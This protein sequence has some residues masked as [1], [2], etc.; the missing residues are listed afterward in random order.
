MPA[1]TVNVEP[2]FVPPPPLDWLVHQ[3]GPPANSSESQQ[4]VQIADSDDLPPD[5]GW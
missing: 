4:S 5:A 1:V 2:A 3:P